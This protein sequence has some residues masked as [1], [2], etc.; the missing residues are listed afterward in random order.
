MI[1]DYDADLGYPRQIVI[2]WDFMIADEET[3]LRAD[4]LI[5]TGSA[6]ARRHGGRRT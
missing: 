2:D 3:F 6:S 1:V 4:R 5:P